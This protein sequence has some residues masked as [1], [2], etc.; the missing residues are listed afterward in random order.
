MG[1]RKG[2]LGRTAA[3]EVELS[4]M[5]KELELYFPEGNEKPHEGR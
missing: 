2:G 3:G 5:F 4:V 1:K